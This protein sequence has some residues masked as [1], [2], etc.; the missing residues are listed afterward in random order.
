MDNNHKIKELTS[1]YR[2]VLEHIDDNPT[3][4]GLIKT[5]ERVAK[6]LDFLTPWI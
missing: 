5:P 1:I 6:A 4:E 2:G 3:R